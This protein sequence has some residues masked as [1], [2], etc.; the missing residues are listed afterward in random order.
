MTEE[1][2]R[3]NYMGKTRR[4]LG[5][6]CRDRELLPSKRQSLPDKEELIALLVKDD[7]RKAKKEIAAE[8]RRKKAAAKKEAVKS[9]E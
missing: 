5:L 2:I 1:K 7:L 3:L 9:D 4:H 8:K 6:L